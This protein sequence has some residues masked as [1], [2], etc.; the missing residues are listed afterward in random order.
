MKYLKPKQFLEWLAEAEPGDKIIVYS[1]P[2]GVWNHS[3]NND[4]TRRVQQI[5][6]EKRDQLVITT[7][8]RRFGRNRFGLEAH[9][10]GPR[11]R[12]HL[13]K[14]EKLGVRR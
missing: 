4:V 1:G 12:R 8:H 9:V 6:N 7:F 11:A 10:L 2:L 13:K 5:I 14:I 3:I